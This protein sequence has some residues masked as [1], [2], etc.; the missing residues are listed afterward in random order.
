MTNRAPLRI[1]EVI[2][3]IE[4]S[5]RQASTRSC[6]AQCIPFD[7]EEWPPRPTMRSRWVR[8]AASFIGPP[9]K[10]RMAK[11]GSKRLRDCGLLYGV[12]TLRV[13]RGYGGSSI[14]QLA[15][16][17]RDRRRQRTKGSA[18]AGDPGSSAKDPWVCAGRST[19]VQVRPNTVQRR[20]T[21]Y[22]QPSRSCDSFGERFAL[23]IW[24]HRPHRGDE[25]D[26]LPCR[27]TLVRA[28]ETYSFTFG[29]DI[30]QPKLDVPLQREILHRQ[31]TSVIEDGFIFDNS[32]VRYGL[33][34]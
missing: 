29:S 23:S 4:H 28:Q 14:H 2:E 30:P 9:T 33:V 25:P 3:I 7:H 22:G 13:D 24:S 27:L 17:T 6:I 34:P 16:P 5:R 1:P 10:R 11:S 15:K 18:K 26:I 21:R 19:T 20:P 31:Y 32:I 8:S 12:G